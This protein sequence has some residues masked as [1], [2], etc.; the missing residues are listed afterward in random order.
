MG[1]HDRAR[2]ADQPPAGSRIER[3]SQVLNPAALGANP[4]AYFFS[5]ERDR[6]TLEALARAQGGGA[7]LVRLTTDYELRTALKPGEDQH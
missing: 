5:P 6:P 3:W 1:A 2:D 4:A 7:R